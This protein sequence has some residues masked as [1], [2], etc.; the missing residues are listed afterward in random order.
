MFDYKKRLKKVGV[1]TIVIGHV[2]TKD[3][4][5]V[6]SG[7]TYQTLTSDQQQNYFNAL[8]KQLHFLGLA[9]IDRSIKTE[10]TGKKNIVTKKEE[11]KNVVVD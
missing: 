4:T 2:K 5:D 7:E 1:E 6:V 8:K 9:Y 11:T 3:V 10:K